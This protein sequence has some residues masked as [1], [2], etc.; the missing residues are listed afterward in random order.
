MGSCRQTA[1]LSSPDRGRVADPR[2]SWAYRPGVQRLTSAQACGSFGIDRHFIK[3]LDLSALRLGHTWH[4]ATDLP[5]SLSSYL[6]ERSHR[7]WFEFM[8]WIP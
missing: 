8:P 7:R 2:W 6:E 1:A 3:P 5:S 4:S